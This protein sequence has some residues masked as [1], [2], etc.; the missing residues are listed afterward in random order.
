MFV[1]TKVKNTY[2]QEI[3]T[4]VD[5][6]STEPSTDS[7]R[8]SLLLLN[9]R[10]RWEE[11]NK[12]ADKLNFS[13]DS[14]GERVTGVYA[15]RSILLCVIKQNFINN[16]EKEGEL[17]CEYCNSKVYRNINPRCYRSVTVDHK[18]PQIEGYDP[19]DERNFAVSCYR[20]NQKKDKIPYREWCVIYK[21]V[22]NNN[23]LSLKRERTI[24][25]ILESNSYK[26]NVI[27]NNDSTQV[28]KIKQIE[29]ITE[30]A[31]DFLLRHLNNFDL[32][33]HNVSVCKDNIRILTKLNIIAKHKLVP[34]DIPID[35][36]YK[37]FF[38]TSI[39]WSKIKPRINV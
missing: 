32:D 38:N 7:S 2:N 18:I 4:Y 14:Y 29:N 21:K 20:C 39:E 35:T 8:A 26:I 3:S 16:K 17:I 30:I 9:N 12:L 37:E 11:V 24:N 34:N 36:K 28:S 1:V 27:L 15:A 23:I 10:L 33:P 19:F 22:L 13:F 6:I 31:R 5:T 25:E